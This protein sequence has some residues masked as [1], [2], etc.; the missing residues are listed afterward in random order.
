[1]LTA[2]DYSLLWLRALAHRVASTVRLTW[3]WATYV[4]LLLSMAIVGGA[5]AMSVVG[6]GDPAPW[7]PIY[8]VCSLSWAWLAVLNLVDHARERRQT[9]QV[10]SI[11]PVGAPALATVVCKDGKTR[12]FFYGP[13]GWQETGRRLA[14]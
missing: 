10:I 12:H 7:P 9:A 5:T 8:L 4:E 6:A 13:G 3:Q 11:K 2:L 1:M 14:E